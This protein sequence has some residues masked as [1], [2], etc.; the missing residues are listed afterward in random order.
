MHI[1][2]FIYKYL[3]NRKKKLLLNNTNSMYNG[4]TI[5]EETFEDLK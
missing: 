3:Q 1:S 5:I 4:I 2:I